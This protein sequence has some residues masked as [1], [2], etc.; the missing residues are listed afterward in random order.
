MNL[1][2]LQEARYGGEHPIIQQI[3]DAITSGEFDFH[4]AITDKRKAESIE[5]GLIAGFGPPDE[6][7]PD[8]GDN[9]ANML[10]NL[11]DLIPQKYREYE[12]GRE[13]EISLQVIHRNDYGVDW[14]ME[15][16]LI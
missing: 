12:H 13:L 8:T 3:K 5:R 1:T 16:S 14:Q 10:W 15:I 6:Q 7:G 2:Q 4:M 9:Y 11:S